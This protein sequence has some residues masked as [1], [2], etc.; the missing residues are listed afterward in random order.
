[1]AMMVMRID[2][3]ILAPTPAHARRCNPSVEDNVGDALVSCL[4]AESNLICNV[5]HEVGLGM[6]R[7]ISIDI[8]GANNPCFAIRIVV[9]RARCVA[10]IADPSIGTSITI[11]E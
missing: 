11:R 9:A 5:G 1:M 10:C 7:D 8:D 6:T 4:G 2:S 3:R